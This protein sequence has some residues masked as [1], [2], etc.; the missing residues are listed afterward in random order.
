MEKYNPIISTLYFLA[1]VAVSMFC[2]NPV[3]LFMALIGALYLYFVRN[4]RKEGRSHLYFL[5]LFLLMV[6]LLPLFNHN[7]ATALFFINGNPITLE[8]IFYGIL[9]AVMLLGTLYWFR[10]FSGL[11]TSDRILYLFGAI[12]PKLALML[13][14]A[15]RY[16]PLLKR[17]AVKIN[18]SQQAIGLYKE[19]NLIDLLR[20]KLRIFSI[21]TTWSLENGIITADSMTARGYGIGHRSC[22]RKFHFHSRDAILLLCLCTLLVPLITAIVSGSMEIIIYPEIIWPTTDFMTV[23]AY[24]SYAIL[25][26]L[27]GIITRQGDGRIHEK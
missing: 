11:M 15:L 21:L 22:Y 17:Q 20:G 14:I 6:I 19:D 9:T 26:L 13:S 10:S 5:L 24:L 2:M 8:A 3:L 16:V 4:G 23:A 18:Q 12:S 27:P 25:V 1:V 7:G